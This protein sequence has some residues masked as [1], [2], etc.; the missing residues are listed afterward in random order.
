MKETGSV[1]GHERPER[2]EVIDSRLI[3]DDFFVIEEARLR[4]GKFDGGMT[5]ELRRLRLI[6]GDAAAC[7]PYDPERELFV[8]VE[9]FRW[10]PW[11]IGSEGWL[12]EI[13]A[14]IVS[15]GEKP[16]EC[17]ARELRE[18]TELVPKRIEHVLTFF[19]TPGG[20]TER[21]FLY[22]AQV[23][24]EGVSGRIAGAPEE[25]EDIRVITL[26]YEEAWERCRDGRI[27]DGKTILA[28]YAFRERQDQRS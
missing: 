8:F 19:S 3:L 16:E 4:H 22:F 7:L 24:S 15:K 18:E 14:G 10:P 21:I 1:S 28:L 2:V 27:H 13:P 5:G 9:Q 23:D 26:S 12:L 6:R 20:S 17:I 25:D 11:S